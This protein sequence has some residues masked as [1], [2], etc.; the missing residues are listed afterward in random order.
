MEFDRD[1]NLLEV[2]KSTENLTAANYNYDPDN[3]FPRYTQ[4]SEDW[5]QQI[6]EDKLWT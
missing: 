1:G 5:Q 6:T 2:W 3:W 4:V